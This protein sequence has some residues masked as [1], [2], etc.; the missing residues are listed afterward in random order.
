M[1]RVQAATVVEEDG[2]PSPPAYSPAPS[3][4]ARGDP[5]RVP[6]GHGAGT[7]A[8]PSHQHDHQD[9]AYPL[10]GREWSPLGSDL[11]QSVYDI[12]TGVADDVTRS[13]E[14]E[15]RTRLAG[16][17]EASRLGSAETANL[18]DAAIHLKHVTYHL[19]RER[20]KLEPQA[21][22]LRAEIL[23]LRHRLSAQHS[24]SYAIV[25]LTVGITLYASISLALWAHGNGGL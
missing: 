21:D 7:G 25:L 16:I 13:C 17:N 6:A 23:V 14:L 15:L 4:P 9:E 3:T 18:R 10:E 19:Q 12:L 5:G 24:F 20:R 22:S 1:S 8:P 2:E 11:P